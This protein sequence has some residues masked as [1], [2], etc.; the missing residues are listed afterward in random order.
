VRITQV[1]ETAAPAAK[2][3]ASGEV[4]AFAEYIGGQGL[5]EALQQLGK[6]I[7]ASYAVHRAD[8]VS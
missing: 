3:P 6:R 2:H 8:G 4:R 5:E 7:E 1:P